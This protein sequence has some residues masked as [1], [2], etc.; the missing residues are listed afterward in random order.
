MVYHRNMRIIADLHIHSR[1]SRATSKKLTPAYLDR[2]A[3]IKGIDL[4][5][6][7]DCTHPAWLAELKEQLEEAEPG[8]YTLKDSIRS[9]FDAT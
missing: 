8:F 9:D 6:S 7:G 2:W 4:V 5:G 1:F 3:A